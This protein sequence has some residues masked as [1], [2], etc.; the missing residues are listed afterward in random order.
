M[1]PLV[2]VSQLAI[3]N[4]V[5]HAQHQS[6]FDLYNRVFAMEEDSLE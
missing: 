5:I 1:Q 2:W 6:L 4:E 3:N